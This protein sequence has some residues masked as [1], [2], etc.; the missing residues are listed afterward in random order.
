MPHFAPPIVKAAERLLLDIEL[1]VRHWPRYHKYA[2]GTHT[3]KEPTMP[4]DPMTAPADLPA[5]P[6]PKGWLYLHSDQS[7]QQVHGYTAAQLQSYALAY[8]AS[9]EG[10]L[11]EWTIDNEWTWHGACGVTWTFTEDGPAEN[12]YH[13]CHGCGKRINAAMKE[14]DDA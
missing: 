7:V 6:E 4:A 3:S 12:N 8:A 1:A 2:S 10:A 5:L 13:Y 11:C 9:R 14:N